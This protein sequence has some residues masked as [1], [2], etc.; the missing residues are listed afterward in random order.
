VGNL[1]NRLERIEKRIEPA[2]RIIVLHGDEPAPVDLPEGAVIIRV[3][4]TDGRESD[5]QRES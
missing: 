5:E 1:N 2:R 3:I 4:Y